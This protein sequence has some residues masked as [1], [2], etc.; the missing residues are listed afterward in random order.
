MAITDSEMSFELL[1]PPQ[2][3]STD[4]EQRPRKKIDYYKA[5]NPDEFELFSIAPSSS[6]KGVPVMNVN[7]LQ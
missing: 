3:P 1:D 6:L 4:L 5:A 2:I 7:A